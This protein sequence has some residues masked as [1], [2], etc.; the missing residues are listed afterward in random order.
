MFRRPGGKRHGSKARRGQSMVEFAIC[1]PVFI[2]FVFGVIQVAL[3]YQ[4]SSSINQ[5][6]SDAAHMTAT[7]ADQAPT[8]LLSWEVDRPALSAIRAA[9]V[10][11]NLGNVTSIDI[12]DAPLAEP[13]VPAESG[14]YATTAERAKEAN[15]QFLAVAKQYSW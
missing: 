15:R 6:A 13:G 8:G 3:I 7:Q 5:A 14:V 12:Y 2:F 10:S 4:A 1:V 9:M 11:Q